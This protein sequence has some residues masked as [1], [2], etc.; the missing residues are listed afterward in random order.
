MHDTSRT[1]STFQSV[2]PLESAT[3]YFRI[4]R[5]LGA[6][7]LKVSHCLWF[8]LLV[9][10]YEVCPKIYMILMGWLCFPDLV[11]YFLRPLG[12]VFD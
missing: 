6:L 4:C 10:L 8:S 12:Q 5:D 2:W 9:F 11:D 7:S 1:S 3:H